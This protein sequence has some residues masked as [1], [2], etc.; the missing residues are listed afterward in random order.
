MGFK[1][2]LMW[3]DFLFDLIGMTRTAMALI[4]FRYFL[5]S[6]HHKRLKMVSAEEN[7]LIKSVKLE[8]PPRMTLKLCC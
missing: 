2:L 4:C 7:I 5:P 3:N 8:S 1:E 6:L